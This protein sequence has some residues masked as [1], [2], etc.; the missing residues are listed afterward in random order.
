ML[1]ENGRGILRDYSVGP[2]EEKMAV[3][4]I[5]PSV[6]AQSSKMNREGKEMNVHN[7]ALK[8]R[9]GKR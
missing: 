6:T 2:R 9:E 7:V 1:L 4:G 3:F 8:L 5:Q